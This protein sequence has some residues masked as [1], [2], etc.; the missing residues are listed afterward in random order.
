MCIR[1]RSKRVAA[2]GAAGMYAGT[3]GPLAS[4]RPKCASLM[5]KPP[6]RVTR[7]RIAYVI[8]AP[9][10]ARIVHVD[11]EDGASEPPATTDAHDE[12]RG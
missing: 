4:A 11:D 10:P 2:N 8:Q 6:G 1:D 7:V 3:E 12:A 5:V 9:R